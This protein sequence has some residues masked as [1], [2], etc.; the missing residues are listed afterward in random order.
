LELALGTTV[1]IPVGLIT[2]AG[3]DKLIQ[4]LQTQDELINIIDAIFNFEIV[5]K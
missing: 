1:H 3:G 2:K 4:S 5:R